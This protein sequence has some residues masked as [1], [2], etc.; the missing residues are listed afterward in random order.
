[1]RPDP[2]G[3]NICS[4]DNSCDVHNISYQNNIFYQSR[5]WLGGGGWE[6]GWWMSDKWGRFPCAK[7]TCGWEGLVRAD[8]NL[9]YAAEPGAGPLV[10]IGEG[11]GSLN[12]FTQNFSA[13]TALT[14]SGRGAVVGEDPRLRGLSSSGGAKLSASTDV[15]PLPGSPTIGAGVAVGWTMDFDGKPIPTTGSVDI[16]PYQS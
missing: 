11:S 12:F 1:M 4:F 13:L 10:K 8:H 3:R 15:H 5:P 16:G 2:S 9:W 7:G 6:A 14:G